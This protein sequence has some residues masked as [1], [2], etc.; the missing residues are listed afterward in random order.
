MGLIK[1]GD[2]VFQD[3]RNGNGRLKLDLGDWLKVASLIVILILTGGKVQWIVNN[4]S[5]AIA[6]Q[7]AQIKVNTER[8]NKTETDIANIKENLIYIRSKVDTIVMKIK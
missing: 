8:L 5:E 2:K 3:R 7:K 1:M 4:H 6:E